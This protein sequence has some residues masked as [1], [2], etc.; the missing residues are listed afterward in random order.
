M[1]LPKLF[2][3]TPGWQALLEAGALGLLIVYSLARLEGLVTAFTFNN[4]M[5]F[6]YGACGMWVVLR[7][8]MP[9]GSVVRQ[10]VWELG[11]AL[12]LSLL[13]WPGMEWPAHFLKWDALWRLSTWGAF[14]VR[15]VGLFTGPG[16][17][18][19]RV[20]LRFWKLWERMRKRRMLWALTHAHLT[21]VAAMA[22]GGTLLLFLLTPYSQIAANALSGSGNAAASAATAWLL[23]FFPVLNLA[24]I[25]TGLSLA[26]VLPPSALFSY[27]VA[28]RTTK[29]LE[30]L[31]AGAGAL[32]AGEYGTRVKVEGEDEVA[33]LQTD[34]NAMAEKLEQTLHDLQQQRDTVT[35][36]LQS[37][38]ELVANVS[39]DLRTPVA[40]LRATLESN[41][42]NWAADAPA[43]AP[44]GPSPSLRQDLET[45]HNE[46][47]RLQAL[48]DDL[49]LLS[50][51][52]A[53]GLTLECRPVD[54]APVVQQMVAAL[55]PLAW[56]SGRVEVTAELPPQLPPA[57]VDERRVEQVLANLLR[58]AV[59]H[60]PP[61]GIVVVAAA[62]EDRCLRLEVRDTGAGIA[63]SDLPHIWDRFY[64]GSNARPDGGAGLGLALVKELTEAMDGTVTVESVLEQGSCFSLRLPR[65]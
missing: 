57:L 18:G 24:V 29:R 41:L 15:L 28:R 11:M 34:F 43:T 4:G 42:D 49:F 65:A 46:V 53:G 16:Y 32:R 40:T 19:M 61:G 2:W 7:A 48:I 22:I 33:R 51:A 1:R 62:V 36:L 52:Q 30:R 35:R 23:T 56:S 20:G 54:L 21:V 6:L 14:S 44:A 59:R 5:F 13:M 9:A 27:W 12:L 17:L 10:A 3:N 58:N 63:P 31:A 38:R 64:R 45:M 60:T 50:Q 55:A 47:L 39:H 37:R 25:F 8:R 26:V